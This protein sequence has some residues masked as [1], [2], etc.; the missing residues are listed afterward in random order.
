VSQV[1]AIKTANGDNAF[2]FWAVKRRLVNAH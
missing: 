1:Q 2:G